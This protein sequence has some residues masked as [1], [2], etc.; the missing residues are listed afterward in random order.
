VIAAIGLRHCDLNDLRTA[1]ECKSIVTPHNSTVHMG[2]RNSF[3]GHDETD[4][5][6]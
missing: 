1:V 5:K 3:S 2:K 4:E 6:V